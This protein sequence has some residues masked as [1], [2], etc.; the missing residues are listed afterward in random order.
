MV[1]VTEHWHKLHREVVEFPFC[2]ELKK[3]ETLL[4]N[5]QMLS[6]VQHSILIL[7]KASHTPEYFLKEVKTFLI[8]FS[9]CFS[10]K[11]SKKL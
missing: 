9:V 6:S 1:R 7:F 8:F 11:P 3:L 2:E 4:G 5:T 10:E